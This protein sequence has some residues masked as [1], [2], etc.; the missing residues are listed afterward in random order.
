MKL[1]NEA[2]V[3][4]VVLAGILV[5]LVGAIWLS[6]QSFGA[7]DRTLRAAFTEVGVLAEGSPVKF[8]GVRVGRV[9]KIELTAG[10]NGVLVTMAVDEGVV[11]PR[12]AGVVISPES[13]FG[14]WQAAIVSRSAAQSQSLDFV[15]IQGVDALPGATMPDITQLTAVAADIAEDMQILSDRVQI[16]FTEET[17]LDIRR[18]IGNVQ[19]VSDQLRGFIDQQTRV[20]GQVSRNVLESTAN[21]ESATAEAS[22]T[23]RDIRTTFNQ[24]EVRQILR[25]AAQASA[26][27]E[28]FS[29]ELSGAA[30]GVPGLVARA[31]TTLAAFGRTATTLDATIG[32]L[33]PQLAQ[34]GPT[35]AEAQ[36]AM[37]TLN[38]AMQAIEQGDGS[39]GR[40]LNDPAL[41]EETQRAIVTLRRLLADIQQNPA[42]YIG[43]LQIF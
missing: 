43:E 22:L 23:A 1:K 15:Q 30:A 32:G 24:G 14:D 28:T 4:A 10:G 7:E 25:N 39:L 9:E 11:L 36:S 12:D 19:D 42:K 34:L 5:A 18:T 20:Y 6:G 41:Y 17:A 3:G 29:R 37:A 33:Q 38:R 8:R 21:I 26:N 40:L 13:F 16:A 2:L 31:D 27:L 35:L